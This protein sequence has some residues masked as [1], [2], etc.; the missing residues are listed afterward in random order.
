MKFKKKLNQLKEN[1]IIL[2]VVTIIAFIIISITTLSFYIKNQSLPEIDELKKIEFYSS[3]NTKYFELNNKHNENYVTLSDISENVIKAILSVEDQH[4][5]EHHGFD[6]KRIVKSLIDNIATMSKK[7]GAST[8]TQ[9]YARN[10][11]LNHEKSITRK[12]KEAYYTIILENNYSKDEILEGYLNTIYFGHGVYGIYDAAKFYFNKHPYYLT[13]GEA[14]V[15]AAIPKG[16]TLYSPLNNYENNKSRKDLIL[17]LMYE[18]KKITKC[19][20]ETA[21]NE[22]IVLIGK[23]PR[24]KT[25]IAPYFQD[26]IMYELEKHPIIHEPFVN[27]IKVYTTLDLELNGIV[28]DAIRNIYAPESQIETAVFAIDPQTGFVKTIIG[29]RNYRYSQYNRALA[30][31]RHPGSTIKPLL[32]YSALEYGFTPTTTFKSEPTTFYVNN[33][34][35]KYSPSNF[36]NI[37]AHN[38][39]TMAYAL[40]VSDNIYAIKTHL[41]LG[42]NTLIRTARR[43]GI[44]ANMLPVPSLALGSTEIKLSEL[45]TAYAHFANLGKKVQPIYITKI[46]DLNDNVLY[47]YQPIEQVQVLNPDVC[48]I[49]NHMLRG[50][51]DPNMSYRQSITGLSIANRIKHIYAGKSGSTDYDNIMIGFNPHLVL[52]VWTGY[53]ELIPI[54]KYEEKGY[55]KRVW[56][57][58]MEDYFANKKTYWYKPTKNVTPVLVNPITGELAS[59]TKNKYVK[60]LYFIKGTEPYYY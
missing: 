25:Q 17:K 15:L 33:G 10:L 58:V 26:I 28:N 23:H 27:G 22:E 43:L 46:T 1:K 57:K 53:D 2:T 6:Y 13:L 44:T 59:K 36:Q 4:F 5:Y 52:G 30:G 31:Q 55:S 45:T 29:G 20:Y 41:F 60:T 12:L 56:A 7:Y 8:I 50:M 40:A 49:L 42:E 9:Q 38:D 11:Y 37:Y 32:Y 35:E 39:V 51:F 19:E 14:A 48:F 21:L 24:N 16:P 18:Q 3:D 47:E 34:S 54:V